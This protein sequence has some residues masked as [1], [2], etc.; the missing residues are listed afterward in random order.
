MRVGKRVAVIGAGNTAMD[1]VRTSLRMGAEEAMIVY[2]RSE[3]EMGA[4]VEGMYPHAVEEGVKFHWLTPSDSGCSA[5]TTTA[6]SGPSSCQT[7][8]LGDPDDSGGRRPV[9][10]RGSELYAG[11]R[12]WS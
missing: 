8:E 3:K 1:A 10:V 9:P 12:T 7:T 6:G 5:T 2:R 11:G 4:R